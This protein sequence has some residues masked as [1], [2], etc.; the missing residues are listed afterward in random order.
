MKA[1]LGVNEDNV[2]AL[3]Y[4][5]PLETKPE[6]ASIDVEM[7][8]IFLGGEDMDSKTVM[9]DEINTKIYDRIREQAQILLVQVAD[10]KG[11]MPIN[12]L[13]VPVT[14]AHQTER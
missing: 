14:V 2:V 1:S 3:F 7:G 13:W 8:Q 6:W 5:E 9:L 11:K 12:A 10:E 4:T